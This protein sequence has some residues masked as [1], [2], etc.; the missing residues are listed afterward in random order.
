MKKIKLTANMLIPALIIF[1]GLYVV[2]T[3]GSTLRFAFLDP[4]LWYENGWVEPEAPVPFAQRTVYFIVWII[5]IL[6]GL[7]GVYAALRLVI[8]LK[9]GVLFDDQV[10]RLLRLVG[11]GT[12]G[13]GLADFLANLLSPTLLSWTNPSGAEPI[14]WYFDSEAGGLIMCGGGFYLIGWVL[15]EA[16]K[17]SDENKSFI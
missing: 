12:A 16:R 13:S 11:I 17:L 6:F 5:P 2:F 3:A 4:A 14:R 10:S 7:F 1:A 15:A 9:R 8:L